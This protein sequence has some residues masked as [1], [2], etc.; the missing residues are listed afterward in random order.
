MSPRLAQ[1][2]VRLH[3]RCWQA[4]FGV[5]FQTFL[6][7]RQVSVWEAVVIA[8]RGGMSHVDTPGRKLAVT[9]GLFMGGAWTTLLFFGNLGDTAVLGNFRTTHL[10]A[11]RTIG[12]SF[13]A[14]AAALAA[15]AGFLAARKF[16]RWGDALRITASSGFISGAIASV[17]IVAME[18]VFHN[19]LSQSPSVLAEFAQSAQA[20]CVYRPVS[21]C[22]TES[23]YL[24]A[25]AGGFNML[26]FGTL[27]GITAGMVGAGL[28]MPGRVRRG[29]RGCPG[30]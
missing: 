17:S 5:E 15:L 26:W 21:S 23:M 20:G 2:L 28:G 7:S 24:D 8:G 10:H 25:L 12:W 13:M 6:E 30:A 22:L 19:A 4:R 3:A 11:Y 18:L 9:F 29:G 16:A 27:T 1:I 14:T